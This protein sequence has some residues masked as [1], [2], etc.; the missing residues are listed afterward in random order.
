VD[1][2]RVHLLASLKV[3]RV[4]GGRYHVRIGERRPDYP[5]CELLRAIHTPGR[6]TLQSNRRDSL[7]I[8]EFP[9][10]SGPTRLA[11]KNGPGEL[12][13]SWRLLSF[14]LQASAPSPCYLFIALLV[15]INFIGLQRHRGACA[16]TRFNPSPSQLR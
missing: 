7:N 3:L 1:C 4:C 10:G 11:E 5:S 15:P 2:G 9:L 14:H 12:S 6:P 13:V 16:C 8:C